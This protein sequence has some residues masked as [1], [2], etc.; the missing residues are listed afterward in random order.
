[1]TAPA[2]CNG[3]AADHCCYLDGVVCDYLEENT[4]PG[5]RWACGLLVR[6]GSW[7]AMS[8]SAEY[9]PIGSHWA[10]IGKPFNYCDTFDPAFCC[11]PEDRQGRRYE[12]QPIPD[13]VVK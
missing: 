9:Q 5:R 6:F 3:N 2:A 8:A 11:V 7:Q 4:V 13:P 10:S 1:M 12:G